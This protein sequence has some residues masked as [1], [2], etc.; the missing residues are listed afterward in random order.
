MNRA[1]HLRPGAAVVAALLL[2]AVGLLL[3]FARPLHLNRALGVAAVL[4]AKDGF[5]AG[6]AGLLIVAFVLSL[7]RRWRPA[8]LPLVAA[9]LII[10]AFC[11]PPMLARGLRNG[12]PAPASSGQLRVLEWNTNGDLVTPATIAALAVREQAN[13]IVLPDAQIGRTTQQYL[14]AFGAAGKPVTVFAAAKPDAQ[15][16]VLITTP[17]A[18]HYRLAATGPDAR[19]TLVLKPTVPNLPR[20]IALH[21]PQPTTPHNM[22]AW[23]TTLQWAEAECEHGAVLAA[24]DFNASVDNFGAD[25]LGT[26]QDAAVQKRAGS[27]GTWPTRLPPVLAMPIDHTLISPST[28]QLD[29]FTVLTG[30]DSSGARHRPTLTV[31]HRR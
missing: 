6:C 4:P 20:I 27:I 19:K 16:A 8:T 22:T 14:H 26:C 7:W 24:G 15:T 5:T 31:I 17:L 30:E 28:G 1:R 13:V 23:R 18:A 3:V 2:L 11:T 10:L 9:L 21:A 25:R 29:S 12:A